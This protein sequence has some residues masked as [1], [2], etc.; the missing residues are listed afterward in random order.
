[1]SDYAKALVRIKNDFDESATITLFWEYSDDGI[2]QSDP[3]QVEPGGYSEYSTV[4]Y[5]HGIGRTGGS[6]WRME[7][8]LVSGQKFINDPSNIFKPG[9]KRCDLTGDDSGKHLTFTVNTEEWHLKMHGSCQT[10][11]EST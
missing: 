6:W 8:Q 9:W 7:V 1:M 2:H 11:M 4:G 3:M 5:Y 10:H